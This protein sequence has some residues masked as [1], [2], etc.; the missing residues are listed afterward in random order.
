[1]FNLRG[2]VNFFA[3]DPLDAK[4]MYAHATGLWRSTDGGEHWN[5]VYPSPDSLKGVKMS[6]DH[7]DEQLIAE[8]DPLGVIAALAVDPADSRILYVAAGPKESQALF[9]SHDS[10]STWAKQVNLPEKPRHI[11][12]DRRSSPES[13]TLFIAGTQA[14]TVVSGTKSRSLALP[15]GISETSLGFGSGAQPT[16]YATS[17]EAISRMIDKH[18]SGAATA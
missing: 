17:K 16:I 12:I 15:T 14:I 7:A 8:P 1:M 6:S 11:W 5:L 10:G 4:I 3:F 2:V 18:V 9:V 13:R